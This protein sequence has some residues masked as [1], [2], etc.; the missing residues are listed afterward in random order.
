ASFYT[1]PDACRSWFLAK[2]TH[3]D[4]IPT[5]MRKRPSVSS[6]YSD[7]RAVNDSKGKAFLTI[8]TIFGIAFLSTWATGLVVEPF[9]NW[10]FRYRFLGVSFVFAMGA[11]YCWARQVAWQQIMAQRY[12]QALSQ[13]DPMKLADSSR[14]PELPYLAATNPWRDS[15]LRF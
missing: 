5:G 2:G 4:G 13:I 7:V 1:S 3:L 12:F 10:P 8:A 9:S 14:A 15:A 11:T 6:S